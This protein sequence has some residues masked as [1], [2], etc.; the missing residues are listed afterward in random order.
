MLSADMYITS[1]GCTTCGS[2]NFY[3]I[4]LSSTAE[5]QFQSVLGEFDD[6]SGEVVIDVITFGDA[7]TVSHG[8]C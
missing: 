8:A 1:T 3:N 2:Q 7:I 4:N 6:A 5:D